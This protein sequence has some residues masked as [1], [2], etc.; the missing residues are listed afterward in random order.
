MNKKAVYG[1]PQPFSVPQTLQHSQF[2]GLGNTDIQQNAVHGSMASSCA[3]GDILPQ[4]GATLLTLASLCE[5]AA[6]NH[7]RTPLCQLWWRR[8]WNLCSG[9][10]GESQLV[11][12][13]TIHDQCPQNLQ[14]T[15]DGC[16]PHTLFKTPSPLQFLSSPHLRNQLQV[17][18]G[19]KMPEKKME[20][21]PE[22]PG[23]SLILFP[24]PSTHM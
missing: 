8:F 20:N 15:P 4:P 19:S 22:F 16:E 5:A 7:H 10:H 21:L 18:L 24:L 11:H 14:R 23:S 13:P 17:L 6:L 9:Y 12:E 2:Q 1:S 3:L